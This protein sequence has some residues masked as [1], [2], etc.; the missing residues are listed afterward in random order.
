MF[1]TTVLSYFWQASIV[2]KGV[3]LIL[4]GVSIVSWGLIFQQSR[5]LR[6]V[7]LAVDQFEKIF[8]SGESLTK[9]SQ[10]QSTA[11]GMEAIFIAGFKEFQRL[12]NIDN[13]KHAMQAAKMRE[14]D[15]LESPLPFLAIVGST[16]P[17]IGL[18]GTVW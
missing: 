11:L 5:Y 15:Q 14:Q 9:L 1:E 6:H 18:F 13:V 2:V 7:W 10:R 12:A 4:V 17:Y 16:G 3:M 8:W